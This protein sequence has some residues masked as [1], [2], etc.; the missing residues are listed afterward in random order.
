MRRSAAAIV[1]ALGLIPS[2]KAEAFRDLE[3]GAKVPNRKMS[4]LDGR[5]ATLLGNAKANVFVFFRTDH[6]RS[7]QVLRQLAVLEKELSP[8][9]VRFVGIVSSE[10]PKDAVAALIREAGVRMPVLV[11]E[12]DAL[13][14]EL[15]V[16]LYPSIGVADAQHTLAAYQPFRQLNFT[17]SMRG[18]IQRVLGEIDDAQL[19]AVLDPPQNPVAVNR[20]KARANLARK[21]LDAGDVDGAIASARKAVELEPEAAEMHAVLA[22]MLSRGGKCAEASRES[23]A[24]RKLDA[25]IALP[26]A[27]TAR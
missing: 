6:D 27:C 15:G 22:E 16:M 24:A 20:G 21:L 26:P 17:D 4:T 18:R 3:V 12:K 7:A 13:Y 2:A 25:A 14:G 5:T 9:P 8:K 19:A 11:D 10:E 1:L 23:S